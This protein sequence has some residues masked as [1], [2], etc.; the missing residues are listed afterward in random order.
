MTSHFAIAIYALLGL[1]FGLAW[2]A[3]HKHWGLE[4][5]GLVFMAATWP[6]WT[7]VAIF[8]ILLRNL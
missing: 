3:M 5:I 1:S 7:T 6:V 4:L 8:A 2:Q